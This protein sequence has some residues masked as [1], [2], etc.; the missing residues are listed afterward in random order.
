MASGEVTTGTATVA[1]A[2]L[3]FE[4]RGAGPV[5]LMIP[6][7]LGDAG[8]SGLVSERLADEYRVVS[9]DRRGHSRSTAGTG[10]FEIAQQSRDAV[11]VLE[12]VGAETAFVFGNSSGA[13]IGLDLAVRFPQI[14]DGLVAHEPPV[15]KLLPDYQD[16]MA[17]SEGIDKLNQEQGPEAAMAQFISGSEIPRESVAP[18]DVLARRKL[19]FVFFL[20]HEQLTTVSFEPDVEALRSS[21]VPLVVGAGRASLESGFRAARAAVELAERLD[22]P[23]VEFPG[24]HGGFQ[25][26][27]DEFA[28]TLRDVLASL[29]SK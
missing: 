2:E 1:G 25:S 26:H 6:G 17:F 29:R 15:I 20:Q 8:S 19:N 21:S 16:L 23:L 4:A 7:G 12:A 11:A 22:L 28:A 9:Y 5:L 3:Y 27:P 13:I 24:H 18:P 14:L 10:E